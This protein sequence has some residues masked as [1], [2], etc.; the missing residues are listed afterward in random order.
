VT[1]ADP[2]V[3][4]ETGTDF[5]RIV[6]AGNQQHILCSFERSNQQH[7]SLGSEVIHEIRG[8][9]SCCCSIASATRRS[10]PGRAIG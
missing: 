2:T 3:F 8:R 5:V 10:K 4:G 7:K 1:V 6:R 9:Q